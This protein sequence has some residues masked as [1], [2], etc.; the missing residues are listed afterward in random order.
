MTIKTYK[1]VTPSRRSMTVTDFSSLTAKKPSKRLT[2]KLN[3]HAG[4]DNLGHIS[5]RHRGGGVKRNYRLI[6]LKQFAKQI[7]KVLTIEYDPYRSAFIA[8]IENQDKKKSYILA[9]DGLKVGEKVEVAEKADIE[10]G[11]RM[12]LKNIPSG[13]QI[14][15]LEVQPRSG[16]KMVRSAGQYATISSKE[17]EY[18]NV[19]LPSGEI[20][21]FHSLCYASIGRLSNIQHSNV[22]IGKAGRKRLMGIRPTVRG[23]AMYPAAHPHGGGEGRNPIGLKY[24]KTPWGKIAIGGKTRKKKKPSNKFIVK[25]RK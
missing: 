1:P 23:K 13:T 22:T 16:G 7:N 18:I 24:P 19:K 10:T 2:V 8:L 9:P 4:R 11:N 17:D 6:D 21:K 15:N 12:Q 5:V 3:T 14:H 25:K 20:R